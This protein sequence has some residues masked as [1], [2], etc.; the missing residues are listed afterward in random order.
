MIRG[1]KGGRKEVEGEIKKILK[2]VGI[3]NEKNMKFIG[4]GGGGEE[5]IRMTVVSLQEWEQ[6]VRLVKERRKLKGKGIRIDDDLTWKERKMR[7][8]L[9]EIGRRERGEGKRIW[10]GYGKI[11]IEGKWWMWEEEEEVLRDNEGKIWKKEG[12][13]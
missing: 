11:Q 4:G 7:W 3:E 10:I 1:V 5:G 8:K 12:E 9:E 6:K 2:E 13:E